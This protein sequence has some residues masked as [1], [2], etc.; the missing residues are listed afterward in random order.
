MKGKYYIIIV[1]V[2]L[3]FGGVLGWLLK[4]DVIINKPGKVETIIR[5]DT[6]IEPGD[7]IRIAGRTKIIYQPYLIPIDTNDIKVASNIFRDDSVYVD[8][9]YVN[10][11]VRR[12]IATEPFTAIFDDIYDGDTVHSEFIFPLGFQSVFVKQKPDTIITNMIYEKEYIRYWYDETWFKI[13]SYSLEAI[14][15]YWLAKN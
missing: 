11:L 5:R 2:I 7:T 9:I 4:P 1:L 14:L 3:L 8:S 15:I 6:L 13:V 12:Y 10:E